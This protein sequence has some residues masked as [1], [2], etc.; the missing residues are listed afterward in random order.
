MLSVNEIRALKGLP[1]SGDAGDTYLQPLNFRPLGI[2]LE[3]G[4]PSQT[5]SSL[6]AAKVRLSA[7]FAFD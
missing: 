1:A 3:K 5:S 7:L 6:D 2:D 4:F